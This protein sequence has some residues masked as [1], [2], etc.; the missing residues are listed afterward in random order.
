MTSAGDLEYVCAARHG[1]L[2]RM[3]EI[4]AELSL[5]DNDE[6]WELKPQIHEAQ[7]KSACATVDLHVMIGGSLNSITSAMRGEALTDVEGSS[8]AGCSLPW[9]AEEWCPNV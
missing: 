2:R 4:Y 5:D 1:L 3:T 6:R 9:E 8:L 7:G